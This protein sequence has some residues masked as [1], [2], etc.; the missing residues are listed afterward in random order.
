MKL[1]FDTETSGKADFK[2]PANDPCQ[3]RLVQL[4]AILTDNSGEEISAVNLLIKP[5]GFVIDAGAEAIHNITTAF[6]TAHGMPVRAAVGIFVHMARCAESLH[7]YNSDFDRI[8]MENEI[9]R[10]PSMPNPFSELTTKVLCEM[11]VMTDICKIPGQFGRYKWP[12]LTE[13]HLHCFGME[14]ANAHDALGDV[15]AM[16]AV[17]KWRMAQP[18]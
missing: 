17:H 13:S 8:I 10:I 1:F 15:R 9:S 7:A 3:P 11:K 6:A 18:L 5:D 14:F 2:K 16:I 4:A 12:S